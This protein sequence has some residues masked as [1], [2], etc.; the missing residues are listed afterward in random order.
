MQ[1]FGPDGEFRRA[2]G[3][4]GDGEGQFRR[5]IGI[6]VDDAGNVYVTDDE[7]PEVQV[8]DGAGTPVRTFG[9][10]GDGPGGLV[11]ATGID[12]D[13]TGT[14]WVADYEA[15]RIQAFDPDRS[16][17]GDPVV[18]EIPG[19][20]GTTGTPE[21]IVARED[22]RIWVTSYRDGEV[23]QLSLDRTASDDE[24]DPWPLVAGGEG[25]GD[26]TFQAPVDL[27]VAPDGT[28]VVTDQQANTVQ[29]FRPDE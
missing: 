19:P 2:W 11:H 4:V 28:L 20:I 27:A 21:G 8:F 3:S 26:G 16:D 29:R 17:G 23:L 7:R 22:G 6:A 10:E 18:H 14:V 13:E 12:V 24:P 9:E 5:A 15:K 1:V 25:I